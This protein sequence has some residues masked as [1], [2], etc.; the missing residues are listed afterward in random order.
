ML[1]SGRRGKITN[2]NAIVPGY[3]ATNNTEALR[4]NESAFVRMAYCAE[5]GRESS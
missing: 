4:G 5:P 1:A 2:V 3:F